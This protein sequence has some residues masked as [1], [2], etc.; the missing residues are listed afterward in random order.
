MKG[1]GVFSLNR[2]TISPLGHIHRHHLRQFLIESIREVYHEAMQRLLAETTSRSHFLGAASDT[3]DTMEASLFTD[4]RT[5][6]EDEI[7]G[8]K[9]INARPVRN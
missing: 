6:H 4:D 9:M 5:G 3:I 7:L 8:T 2:R 1:L